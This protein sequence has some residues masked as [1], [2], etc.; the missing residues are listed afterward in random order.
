MTDPTTP[1]P[2]TEQGEAILA[3]EPA[4][5]RKHGR[6]ASQVAYPWRATVRT[7]LWAIVSFAAIA[8]LIYT[9]AAEGDPAQATGWVGVGLGILGGIQRVMTL[10]AVDGFLQKHIPW[11]AAKPPV[12]DDPS[13]DG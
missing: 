4:P 11:L 1:E 3:G 10:P 5:A 12:Q 6:R 13:M 9:A 7:V 2:L 8:P